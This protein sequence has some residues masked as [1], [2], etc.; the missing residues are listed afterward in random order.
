MNLFAIIDALFDPS[1][2]WDMISDKD[3]KNCKFMVNRLLSIEYPE[4]A[5]RLNHIRQ[6]P[7]GVIEYWRLYLKGKYRRT[8]QFMYTKTKAIQLAREKAKVK[9]DNIKAYVEFHGLGTKDIEWLL[10]W[11]DNIKKKVDEFTKGK[12]MTI[13]K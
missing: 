9:S 1:D 12:E 5:Q 4:T 13:K 6:S 10:L 11:D 7:T 2:K 3:K 8:P